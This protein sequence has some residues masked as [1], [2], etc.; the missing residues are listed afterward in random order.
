MR[1][2]ATSGS[3]ASR[4]EDIMKKAQEMMSQ[5]DPDELQKIQEQ[6]TNMSDSEKSTL[7]Q[8]GKDMGIL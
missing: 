4:L 6:F 1:L 5:M 3:I 8:Q 7:M 2:N